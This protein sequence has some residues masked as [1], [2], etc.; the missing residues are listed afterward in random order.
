MRFSVVIPLFNKAPTICRAVLS[1]QRQTL[2]A[3]EII[4]VDDGSTDGGGELV[5]ARFPGL[6][7]VRQEN[8]GEGA[9]RN[10]GFRRASGD[11]VAFLDADDFWTSRHLATLRD[12]VADSPSCGFVGTRSGARVEEA[13]IPT[14]EQEVLDWAD[15]RSGRPPA[16]ARGG[17]PTRAAL[18]DYLDVAAGRR[19]P[20]N[21]SS[22]AV[23]RELLL[24]GGVEFPPAPVHADLAVWCRLGLEHELLLVEDTT[25][26]TTRA[27]SSVSEQHRVRLAGIT[28]RDCEAYRSRPDYVVV[29]AAVENAS[30][31]AARRRSAERY[32]DGVVTRHWPTVLLYAEQSCAREAVQRLRAPWDL[33]AVLLRIAGSLPKPVAEIVARV[34]RWA[35]A[36]A[37][38]PLPVSPF[39]SRSA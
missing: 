2:R 17:T 19:S 20:V 37:R 32:L 14:G 28:T 4:V 27:A 24:L 6:T 33:R 8:H 38:L 34:L 35:I 21:A 31:D 13:A 3:H 23:R 36:A 5:A 26:V 10:A 7:V 11:W 12:A 18:V 16:T 1:V 39:A 22:V 25:V 9:A 15:R 30:L 29:E